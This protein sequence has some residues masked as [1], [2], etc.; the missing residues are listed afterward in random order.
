MLLLDRIDSVFLKVGVGGMAVRKAG[1]DAFCKLEY[2]G[3]KGLKTKIVTVK[4]ESAKQ[5]NPTFCYELWYPVSIPATTQV[6][7]FCITFDLLG[8]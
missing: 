2:G 8:D 4:G 3:A 5:I 6:S 7:L 1:T